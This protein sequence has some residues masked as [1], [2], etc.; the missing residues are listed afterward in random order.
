VGQPI[1]K[2]RG[3]LQM[4]FVGKMGKKICMEMRGKIIYW[5]MGTGDEKVKSTHIGR[6]W[7]E[8]NCPMEN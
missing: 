3:Y 8:W 4:N 7:W 6:M 1:I 2:S 5:Q